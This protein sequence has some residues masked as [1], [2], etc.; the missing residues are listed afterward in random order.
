MSVLLFIK[1]PTICTVIKQFKIHKNRKNCPDSKEV[2]GAL[3]K[4][5]HHIRT[6]RVHACLNNAHIMWNQGARAM[7]Y[8]FKSI[9]DI[10]NLPQF[11]ILSFKI[12]SLNSNLRSLNFKFHFA[13][14]IFLLLKFAYGSMYWYADKVKDYDNWWSFV[15]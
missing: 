7:I 14:K 5:N 2:H 3:C 4:L 1:M 13:M 12:C 10:L 15:R 6:R 8:I 9:T 11:Y